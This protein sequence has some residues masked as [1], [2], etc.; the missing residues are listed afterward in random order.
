M[1]PRAGVAWVSDGVKSR[2]RIAILH[3]YDSHRGKAKALLSI[4][5]R[6]SRR[7]ALDPIKSGILDG[8]GAKQGPHRTD[9]WD[10]GR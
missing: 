3:P 9:D 1:F 6:I 8:P 7:W 10:A 5:A 4:S 2:A